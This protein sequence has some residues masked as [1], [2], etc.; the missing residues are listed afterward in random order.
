MLLWLAASLMGA[1][2]R[3]QIRFIK[4]Y[5]VLLSSSLILD[6]HV[7]ANRPRSIYQYSR[8]APRLSGQN[9][10]FFKF[11]LS[12][13]FQKRLGY[14]ENNTKYRILTRKSRSH[15][16]ILIYQTWPIDTCQKK[17]SADLYRVIISRAQV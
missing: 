4:V 17:I 1:Y 10:Y 14:K 16:R 7:M 9:C 15:V 5:S 6:I 12:L 11:L 8:T 2:S 13:N 3:R